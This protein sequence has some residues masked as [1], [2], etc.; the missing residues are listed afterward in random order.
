MRWNVKTHNSDQ[1]Q[2]FFYFYPTKLNRSISFLFDSI[3][4]VIARKNISEETTKAISSSKIQH[5]ISCIRKTSIC[6]SNLTEVIYAN[7]NNVIQGKLYKKR[8]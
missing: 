6:D 7:D 4:N 3:S 2:A 1:S 5:E 8:V